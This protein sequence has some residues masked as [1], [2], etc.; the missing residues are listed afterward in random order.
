[1]KIAYLFII[2]IFA[3]SVFA[4]NYLG[5]TILEGETK[6]FM[7]NDRVYEI[8]LVTVSDVK[9]VA[10]FKV[11]GELSKALSDREKHRF[12]DGTEIFVSNIYPN[13]AAEVGGGDM[14]EFYFA[15]TG[16]SL[17]KK[18]IVARD[19]EP[20]GY[21][22]IV[23]MLMELTQGVPQKTKYKM[24]CFVD[25]DCSDGDGCTADGCAQGRCVHIDQQGCSY[26]SSVCV[27]MNTRMDINSIPRYCNAQ[28][29]WQSQRVLGEACTQNHECQTNF[30]YEGL[31]EQFRSDSGK[32]S[33]KFDVTS[34]TPAELLPVPQPVESSDYLAVEPG[35][36]KPMIVVTEPSIQQPSSRPKPFSFFRWLFGKLFF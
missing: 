15:A 24:E 3:T 7:V 27:A 32:A 5:N 36:E 19:R 16:G 9:G 6:E 26:D 11:N 31:C 35:V 20:E 25:T 18:R 14:V 17:S 21:D 34:E 28:N 10:L 33:V 4:Q 22:G 29:K 13:E 8:T 12:S 2:L 23:E 1:M 30:C